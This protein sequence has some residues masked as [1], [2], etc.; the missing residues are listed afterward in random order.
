[1]VS[2]D[3]DVVPSSCGSVV[4]THA[5]PEL[6]PKKYSSMGAWLEERRPGILRCIVGG[7]GVANPCQHQS[8]CN[9]YVHVQPGLPDYVDCSGAESRLLPR[10]R[11]GQLA[12]PGTL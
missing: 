8:L 3:V 10:D 9:V 4:E 12:G 2:K 5:M 6:D 11:V 7:V 1:M